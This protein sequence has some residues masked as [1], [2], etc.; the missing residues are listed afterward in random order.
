MREPV[1]PA[2][3]METYCTMGLSLEKD[4]VHLSVPYDESDGLWP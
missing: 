4:L 2:S 3:I 1:L